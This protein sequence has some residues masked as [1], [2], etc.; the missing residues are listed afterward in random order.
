MWKD[1]FYFSKSDRRA[2]AFFAVVIL[3]STV[4]R[5]CVHPSNGWIDIPQ[6]TDTVSSRPDTAP[7]FANVAMAVS[8]MKA[9]EPRQQYKKQFKYKYGTVLDLNISDTSEL[10]KVPGIGSYFARR[11]VEYRER[12]GGYV[13]VNQL[14]EIDRLPDSVRHWFMISDTFAVRKMPINSSSLTILKSHPYMGFYR[15]RA[16]VD[17]RN[18]NGDIN[19]TARLSLFDEFSG[20]D[21]K[22]LEPYLDFGPSGR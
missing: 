6:E 4:I 17:Y 18:R 12:L 1:F 2:I 21:L 7:A 3:T 13:S 10:K 5:V 8:E 14:L 16:I 22:R 20:Q 15:A 11:I 9:V 19:D